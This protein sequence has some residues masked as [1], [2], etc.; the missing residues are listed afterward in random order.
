M[1]CE[2]SN[3]KDQNEQFASKSGGFSRRDFIRTAGPVLAGM[4]IVPRH[5]LG[6]VGR[7][8]PSETIQVAG[9]GIGGVGRGQI[10]SISQQA[11]TRIAFLC[12]VDDVYAKRT[13]DRFPKAKVYRDYR[14]M[15]N[16]EDDKIDAVYC[17]TPDHTHTVISLAALRKGKRVL[18]VKPLTRTI[19]ESRLLVREARKAGVATQVTASSNT[20]DGVCRLCEMIWDGAIG[21]VRE[22][23][24]WSNRPLWP[25]GMLR[26]PGRDPVPKTLDWDLWIGP[27][28]MRPF[29][30]EWQDGDTAL[31]QVKASRKPRR[32][33]YHPW[34]FRGWWDFGTGALG[35]MGCHHFNHVFKALKLRYPTS[36]SASA[37]MVFEETA[38][39]ASIVTFEF[40]ARDGMPPLRLV[41]YDGGLKPPR[42][43]QLEA[44][45]RLPGSGE[46]YIGDKGIILGNRIIP[47]S[48]MNA[49][50]LP[51]KTLKRRSGTWGEW[52]EA[53]RGGEPAGCNFDWAQVITE[54]VLLGNIAIRSN[55]TLQWD[56][57]K[58]KFANNDKAN[59]HVKPEYRSGWTIF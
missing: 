20:S 14:E 11:G 22:A 26:P 21:D 12:D 8:P 6:G 41:W 59:A 47:E 38:P 49:Y 29:V 51:P 48:K 44:G 16:A 43:R 25:Q 31:K 3:A 27:A 39:L 23:H 30:A 40:P 1:G 32:A 5:V 42:P 4:T 13:Y 50:K 37:S 58:M 15:L 35:D 52:V 36:I 56:A 46:M 9:I 17:G 34:N 53:I 10:T 28:Q 57:E 24:V 33:V 54:A 18:C 7:I 19:H 55:K 2:N 45:R